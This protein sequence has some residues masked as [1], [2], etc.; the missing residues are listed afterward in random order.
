MSEPAAKPRPQV[1]LDDFERRLRMGPPSRA[2]ED[3][4]SELARIVGRDDPFK[5]VFDELSRQPHMQPQGHQSQAKRANLVAQ[6]A[7]RPEPQ[8]IEP[9]FAAAP[10]RREPEA[11][12]FEQPMMRPPSEMGVRLAAAK[13]VLD[14]SAPPPAG[15][16]PHGAM[17]HE[18]PHP[19]MQA[20]E[21]YRDDTQ[22]LDSQM[23]DMP[24]PRSY[25][26]RKSVIVAA[27]LC[28]VAV[29]GVAG[30]M[31]FRGKQTA[32]TARAAPTIKAPEG[33]L[34]VAAAAPASDAAKPATSILDKSGDDKP[35][36]AKVVSRDEQPVD[37]AA[38][39]KTVRTLR[40]GGDGKPL[41]D[42]APATPAPAL[43]SVAT[44]LSEPKKVKTV[45]VRPDGSVI[46]DAATPA[47]AP[48][49][50]ASLP[51]LA[52]S[53]VTSGQTPS[54]KIADVTAK[55]VPA[56]TAS[57]APAAI[58]KPVARPA[59][60]AAKPEAEA[61]APLSISALAAKPAPAT[62][63]LAPATAKIATRAASS[64]GENDGAQRVAA[65]EAPKPTAEDPVPTTSS[66]GGSFA[67]QLAAPPSEAEAKATAAR[68]QKTY[69]DALG[70]Y[71]PSV[72]KAADKDVYRVRVGNL[73]KADADALCGRLKASGGA[74]FVAK[75]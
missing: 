30:A 55:S 45:L 3:P 32:D 20:D 15:P 4:L 58:A 68:L 33:P 70:G 25:W 27:A 11:P 37:L 69:A 16:A 12:R 49:Q 67:V 1:N 53:G 31:T 6:S 36:Q 71:S 21:A 60:T 28:G 50:I 9:A 40:V 34:K 52:A 5:S 64:V 38:Q 72:R 10:P 54:P 63:N 43:Q 65:I 66:T 47:S 35:G 22:A 39:P 62:A 24:P 57:A 74:C 8:R 14:F 13:T 51:Q 75:N 61:A 56:T 59:T 7:G 46:G 2:D 29:I 48:R 42:T 41:A 17:A 23:S 73:S 44:A 18:A 19:D 26:P